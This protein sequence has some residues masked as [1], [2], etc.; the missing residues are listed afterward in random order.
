MCTVL[1]MVLLQLIAAAAGLPM[2]LP[3]E[4]EGGLVGDAGGD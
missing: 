4:G 2:E 1:A 3:V